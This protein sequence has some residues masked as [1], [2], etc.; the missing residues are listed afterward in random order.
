MCVCGVCP[1][2]PGVCVGVVCCVSTAPGVCVC[3]C[4]CVSTAPGVCVCVWGMFMWF[5]RTQILY[6]N[7]RYYKEKVIYEVIY[8]C[9]HN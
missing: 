4:V 3:V 6:N 7:Y 1:L 8:Q 9:P 5:M 2:P